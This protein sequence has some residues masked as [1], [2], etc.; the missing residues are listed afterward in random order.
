MIIP[1]MRSI[2]YAD[3]RGHTLDHS[4]LVLSE[5]S[6]RLFQVRLLHK[7]IHHPGYH[8]VRSQPYQRKFVDHVALS[9]SCPRPILVKTDISKLASYLKLFI[10]IDVAPQP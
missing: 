3:G 9:L 8:V 1:D 6:Q 4:G 2:R 10:D 5:Q 7:K